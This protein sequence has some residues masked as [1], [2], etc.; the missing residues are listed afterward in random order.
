[1][2]IHTEEGFDTNK[3]N[4][5]SRWQND[6][7]SIYNVPENLGFDNTFYQEKV[8]EKEYIENHMT[9]TN[10]AVNNEIAY[11]EIENIV[12]KLQDKKAVDF[13]KIPNEVLNHHDVI[14]SL[15]KLFN[16]YFLSG[17]IPSI[18]SLGII[19][20]IP[21]S[22]EKDPFTPLNY[23]GITL[24]SCISKVYSAVLN[25]R[26]VSYC[27]LLDIF[28]EEQNGFRKGRS[29]ED[30]IFTLTSLIKNKLYD[31]EAVFASFIDLE[32]AFDWEAINSNLNQT[33]ILAKRYHY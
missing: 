10:T 1:M 30:H 19:K 12:K 13:D 4:I 23:R 9:E 25:A 7:E 22:S 17:L 6:F 26:V 15:W 11:D 33:D 21:K 27:E 18:W 16:Q 32:E 28:T 3:E 5:K 14:M 20:P 29:C 8:K 2:K 24:L 31:K